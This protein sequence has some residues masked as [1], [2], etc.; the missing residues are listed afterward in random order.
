MAVL[1]SGFPA[2]VYPILQP[3]DDRKI[4]QFERN[5]L[6]IGKP[7]DRDYGGRSIIDPITTSLM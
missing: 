6:P 2:T 7:G 1:T 3:F 5:T 4:Q